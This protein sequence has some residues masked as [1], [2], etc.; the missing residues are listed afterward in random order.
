MTLDVEEARLFIEPLKGKTI[1]FLINDRQTN[2]SLMRGMSA[3]VAMTARGFTIFDIDAFF[4]S[5]SGEILSSLSSDTAESFCINV[6]EP[7]SDIETEFSKVFRTDSD[8]VVIQSLNTLYHLFRSSGTGSRMRKV[9]FAMACLSH[10]AKT[11][12]KAV[13]VIMY[14]RDRVMKVGNRGSISDLSDATVLVE[15][16]SNRLSLKC[17]RGTLW[18]RGEFYLRLP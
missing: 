1:T 11:G 2:L 18:P 16:A 8:V 4:S 3:L 5:N 15:N 6:P 12:G 17:K 14:G 7:L 13:M 9:A 10:F